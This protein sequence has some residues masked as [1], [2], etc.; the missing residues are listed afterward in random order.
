MC[1]EEQGWLKVQK[2]DQSGISAIAT[3]RCGN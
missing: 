3:P 2:I 1:D